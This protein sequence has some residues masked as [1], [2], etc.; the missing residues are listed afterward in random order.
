MCTGA[1]SVSLHSAL[2]P[3]LSIQECRIPGLSPWNICVGYLTGG[4]GTCQGDSGGPLACQASVWKLV[5]AASWVQ[6]CG[7]MNKP[8]VYTSVTYALPW[9]HQTMEE[10]EE[11]TV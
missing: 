4:T 5:G 8:G 10:E 6:D 1:V 2:V 9:I 11:R 3:F 7:K